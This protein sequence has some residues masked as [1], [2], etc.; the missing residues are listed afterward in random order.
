VSAFRFVTA[1]VLLPLSGVLVGLRWRAARYGR[2]R[3]GNCCFYGPPDFL[4]IC[5]K[6]MEQLSVLDKSVYLSLLPQNFR[7]WYEP[8]GPAVFHRHFGISE[9]YVAWREQGVIACV[10]Y[11]HFEAK[12]AHGK[13]MWHMIIAEPRVVRQKIHVAVRAWLEDHRFP[14]ELA[15][16]FD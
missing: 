12:L 9:S 11:A 13:A 15:G 10:L 3:A 5:S 14:A 2:W 16:C 8:H 7:I 4:A 1:K 6:A